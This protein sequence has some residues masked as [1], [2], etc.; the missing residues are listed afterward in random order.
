MN[1]ELIQIFYMAKTDIFFSHF[2]FSHRYRAI[3]HY[4]KNSHFQKCSKIRH[5]FFNPNF[6][7][8]NIKHN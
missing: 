4:E 2:S 3:S 1:F 8:S 5:V 7:N 6:R